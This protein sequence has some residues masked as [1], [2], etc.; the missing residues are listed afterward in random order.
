M[1]TGFQ[2]KSGMTK[3]ENGD[4]IPDQVWNDKARKWGLDSRSSLV[5]FTLMVK[6]FRL[7]TS[8][9]TKGEYRQGRLYNNCAPSL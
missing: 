5:H 6:V 1:G 4:W 2:I 3:E 7:R 9:M 8:R